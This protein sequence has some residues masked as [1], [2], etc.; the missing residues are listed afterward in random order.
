ML[1]LGGRGTHS[2]MVSGQGYSMHGQSWPAGRCP[3]QKT[4]QERHWPPGKA[5]WLGTQRSSARACKN[6]VRDSLNVLMAKS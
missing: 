3:V 2:Y 6:E 5:G 4:V 1:V